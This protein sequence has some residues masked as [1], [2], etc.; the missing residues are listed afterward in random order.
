MNLNL[1][2]TLP[3]IAVTA[4]LPTIAH[5]AP[6]GM[7]YHLTG[8]PQARVN[9]AWGSL[10]L[11][12]KLEPGDQVRCGQGATAV[13]V[14][15]KN[16]ERFKIGSGATGTVAADKIT[17]AQSAGKLGGPSARVAKSLGGARKGAVMARP[18]SAPSSLTPQAPGWLTEK[19]RTIAW[20][21]V[22]TAA[23]Y[24]F[25]L[26]DRHAAVWAGRVN[27]AKVQL[28]ATIELQTRVPYVWRMV[29]NGKSAKALAQ[30][31]RWGVVTILS[32]A[33][34]KRLS[35]DV[36][37]LTD[38][39]KQT[40]DEAV[41]TAAILAELYAEYGVLQKTIELLGNKPLQGL[42]GTLEA[43]NDANNELGY[44]GSLFGGT[45][46]TGAAGLGLDA[47]PE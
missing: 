21:P 29:P 42:P 2:Q 34:A 18:G 4:A 16:G 44:Y 3:L 46:N 8:K 12:Q 27:D 9:G 45:A 33:D 5:A 41:T 11:L 7:A 47:L 43:L 23:S 35:A 26:F 1:R 31:D 20:T 17:G 24:S 15:F 25:V 38:Y 6:V 22:E 14:L 30:G 32:E 28:P 10:R 13:I 36:K 39:M 19:E 37:E 40:P